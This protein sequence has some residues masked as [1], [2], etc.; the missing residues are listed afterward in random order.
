[1]ILETQQSLKNIF[2]LKNSFGE[3]LFD[4]KQIV[5]LLNYRFSELGD[6]FG[7]ARPYEMSTRTNNRKTIS[8]RFVTSKEVLHHLKTLKT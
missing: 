1:M 7:K 2:S 6:Y 8:F 3:I 5:N 4:N